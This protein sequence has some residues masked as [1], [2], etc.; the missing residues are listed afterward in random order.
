MYT[1][2]TLEI[3]IPVVIFFVAF[4]DFLDGMAARLLNQHSMLG[5]LLDPARDRM[6]MVAVLANIILIVN[7]YTILIWAIIAFEIS[8]LAIHAIAK[9]KYNLIL[10][11]HTW[12]KLRL[13][14]HM[15]CAGLFTII[16]YWPLQWEANKPLWPTIDITLLLVVMLTASMFAAFSY[17]SK[18]ISSQE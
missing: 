17:L 4:S 18:L 6:L 8:I 10:G 12:G 5:K 13:L 7:S 1:T 16:V 14:V 15:I 11:V 3:L 2:H 9:Y